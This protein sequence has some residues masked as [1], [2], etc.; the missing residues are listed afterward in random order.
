[1]GFDLSCNSRASSALFVDSAP[2]SVKLFNEMSL[3]LGTTYQLGVSRGTMDI[4][5]VSQ[6]AVTTGTKYYPVEHFSIET[7]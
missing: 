2:C 6:W 3:C 5:A 7:M 4:T 1:M